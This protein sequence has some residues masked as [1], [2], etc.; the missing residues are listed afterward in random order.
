MP[1]TATRSPAIARVLR[2]PLN[3]VTPAQP[4]GAASTNDSPS[5]MRAKAVAGAVTDSA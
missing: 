2:S 4:R 5:G 1:S 3:V